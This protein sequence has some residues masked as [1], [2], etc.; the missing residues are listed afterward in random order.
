MIEF[1]SEKNI[2]LFGLLRILFNERDLE[3]DLQ[4]KYPGKYVT[5]TNYGR[6]AFQVIIDE[7]GL[8]DCKIMIPAFICS[9]FEE[10]FEKNNITPILIDVEKS[11]FNISADT[12]KRG[13]DKSAKALLTNNMNGLPCEIE[14]IKR[15]L[16]RDQ[17][18]IE[19]CAHALGAIHNNKFVGLSGDAAF[20]SLYKNL[21]TISGGFA[22]TSAPLTI[23]KREKIN[24][25]TIKSLVYLIGNV[26]NLYKNFKNDQNLYD[27]ELVYEK[28]DLK[29]PNPLTIKLASYY[30]PQLDEMIFSRQRTARILID[31]LKREG[32]ELQSNPKNE[33]IYTYFSFLLPKSIA[34]RRIEFLTELKKQGVIGRIIWDKPLNLK[35]GNKCPNT[36]EISERIV[37]VPINSNYTIK[38]A[39]LLA[40]KVRS[41]LRKMYS[42]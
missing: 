13:F 37:G 24:L 8:K 27:E 11:T 5:L 22:L 33:H 34:N 36:K 19:D 15:I 31:C 29:A 18:L 26:A 9:V 20:F 16:S 1:H 4:K 38:E 40:K 17:I 12:L 41:A 23:L 3:S 39:K 2:K 28:V 30:V 42:L 32:V 25:R 6:T 7:Y 21:P 10:I 35:M 14:K